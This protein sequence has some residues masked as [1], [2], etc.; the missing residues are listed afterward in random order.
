MTNNFKRYQLPALV[1]TGLLAM[2]GFTV[3][4]CYNRLTF[5]S[6]NSQK[7]F[8]ADMQNLNQL[9]RNVEVKGMPFVHAILKNNEASYLPYTFEE[10]DTVL[11]GTKQYFKYRRDLTNLTNGLFAMTKEYNWQ[12]IKAISLDIVKNWYR[13]NKENNFS[14]FSTLFEQKSKEIGQILEAYKGRL[15]PVAVD[16]TQKQISV[17]QLRVT[18][19]QQA[20]EKHLKKKLILETVA[21]SIESQKKKVTA[22]IFKADNSHLSLLHLLT[23]LSLSVANL[24]FFYKY[25]KNRTSVT[26]SEIANLEKVETPAQTNT[27]IDDNIPPIPTLTVQT[28]LS[29][30]IE[31][32]LEDLA[33]FIQANNLI[34]SIKSDSEQTVQCDPLYTK[35]TFSYL[36]KDLAVLVGHSQGPR[37]LDIAV[38]S[39]NN[40]PT[41]NF[42]LYSAPFDADTFTPAFEKTLV[43]FEADMERYNAQLKLE[44]NFD[45]NSDFLFANISVQI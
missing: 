7:S 13:L 28:D 29:N 8:E 37:K 26:K 4:L 17:I 31:V 19:L 38:Y 36:L 25:Q 39:E 10:I 11:N 27:E 15:N 16:L 33:S 43:R 44:N 40:R 23:L 3:H 18:E 21:K 32:V 35:N 30:L 5:D 1:F 42:I 45:S 34:V 12:S 9:K 14:E 24:V 6:T 2:T 41:I 20:H 22:A